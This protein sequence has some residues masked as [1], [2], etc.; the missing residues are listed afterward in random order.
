MLQIETASIRSYSVENFFWKSLSTCHKRDFAEP[1][2]VGMLL[3]PEAGVS[4]S[5]VYGVTAAATGSASGPY[6]SKEH[7]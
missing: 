2:W 3:M 1:G 6:M 4:L 7:Q 5:Q